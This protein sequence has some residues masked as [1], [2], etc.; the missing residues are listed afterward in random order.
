ME[1]LAKLLVSPDAFPF[2]LRAGP[3]CTKKQAPHGRHSTAYGYTVSPSTVAI[4]NQS[5]F[6]GATTL[7]LRRKIKT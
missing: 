1:C 4:P 5:G 6:G 2:R 3:L 7:A